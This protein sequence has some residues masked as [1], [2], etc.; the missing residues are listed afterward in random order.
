MREDGGGR[1]LKKGFLGWGLAAEGG[2][3]AEGGLKAGEPE[4]PHRLASPPGCLPR[5][6]H[7]ANIYNFFLCNGDT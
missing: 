5:P 1:E 2:L 7:Q 6:H 3:R 4:L